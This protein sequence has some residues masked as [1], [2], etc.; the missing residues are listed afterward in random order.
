MRLPQTNTELPKCGANTRL[1][2]ISNPI[3]TAPAVKT[4]SFKP[5]LLQQVAQRSGLLRSLDLRGL[6]LLG[7]FLGFAS[8]RHI[9]D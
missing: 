3:S 2:A 8:T 4:S 5:G 9:S 6:V 1:P 7:S